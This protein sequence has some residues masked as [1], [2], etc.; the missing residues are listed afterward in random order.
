M[1][2]F[3]VNDPPPPPPGQRIYK[4]WHGKNKF[5]CGGRIFLG[6]DTKV[7]YLT[8]ILI[9][10]P[11]TLFVVFVATD[12]SEEISPAIL[13]IGIIWPIWCLA[14]LI[15]TST[16]DPGIFPRQ[17]PPPVAG[18]QFRIKEVMVNG[19]VMKWKWCDTCNIYRQPRC[20]HCSVCDNCVDKF[21]HH[22]PWVGQCVG[23]RN[24]RYFILF[25]N[26][27]T[28]LC[29][30]VLVCSS[31]HIKHKYDD[32]N[33]DTDT[34]S[35]WDAIREAPV[36][37]LL[38]SYT[39]LIVWF[40]GG[41]SVFHFYLMATNQT[42]YENFRHKDKE[43]YPYDEGICNNFYQVLCTKTPKSLLRG[44]AAVPNLNPIAE[45]DTLA[46]ATDGQMN[47][48]PPGA[49]PETSIASSSAYAPPPAHAPQPPVLREF[50][51]SASVPKAEPEWDEAEMERAGIVVSGNGRSS[52]TA[53]IEIEMDG[54]S[55]PAAAVA[56]QQGEAAPVTTP[57]RF[58]ESPRI[59]AGVQGTPGRSPTKQDAAS[60][61]KSSP[62]ADEGL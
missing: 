22:C 44:H 42:T 58:S 1:V 27:T 52:E 17:P 33:E 60:L 31:L 30:F 16:S 46:G 59:L 6:P 34:A 55:D 3:R 39:F 19:K 26:S 32:L 5:Y 28:I 56:T 12:L 25:I 21:D 57:G 53:H 45:E 43:G 49:A 50:S 23:R 35:A 7:M 18:K 40:V 20:S 14:M 4:N 29:L 47:G 10:V 48:Y 51:M 9:I 38:I 24:Y 15:K 8:S 13:V 54:F 61:T 37:M 36:S 41:L 2:D 62:L 11:A